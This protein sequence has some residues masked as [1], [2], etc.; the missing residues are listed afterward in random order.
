MKLLKPLIVPWMV[1]P[2]C[3]NLTLTASE[4]GE[5]E[6]EFSG[7]FGFEPSC[8]A[9]MESIIVDEGTLKVNPN[10]KSATYQLIS[11]KFDLVGWFKRSPQF[12]D[13]EVIKE[14]DYD[15]SF[16]PGYYR[17]EENL[18]EWLRLQQQDWE[19][20]RICNN[21]GVYIVENSDWNIGPD[22]E[23]FSLKH[24][25]IVG[26]LSYIEIMAKSCIWESRGNLSR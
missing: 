2:S 10:E 17:D 15:W 3:P 25:L 6:I 21:P 9:P 5:H 26:E 4:S 22:K 13:E 20:T 19:K 1:A 16:V 12:S 18:A 24:F 11:L 7:F 8:A 14:S 23:R